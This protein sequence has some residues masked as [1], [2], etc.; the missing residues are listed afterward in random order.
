MRQ[1]MRVNMRLNMRQGINTCGT[2]K[3]SKTT[4]YLRRDLKCFARQ[5]ASEKA[6]PLARYI[7]TLLF[8]ELAEVNGQ[9]ASGSVSYAHYD[10]S[11]QKDAASAL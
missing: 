9:N 1:R 3:R 5:A 7:E 4:L 11:S 10:I 6:E 2:H 8:T